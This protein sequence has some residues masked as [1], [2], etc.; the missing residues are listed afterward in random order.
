MLPVRHDPVHNHAVAAIRNSRH[1]ATVVA[2]GICIAVLGAIYGGMAFS[3]SALP[4][5][6]DVR[7]F[8]GDPL[9]VRIAVP[10][11]LERESGN[12][13]AAI[14]RN[15][16]DGL[17]RAKDLQLTMVELRAARFILVRSTVAIN[18]PVVSFVLRIGCSGEAAVDR[19][20]TV[21]LD[22]PPFTVA[23]PVQVTDA[24][25]TTAT[26]S[27]ATASG[28]WT[29]VEGDTLLSIAKGIHPRNRVRQ[30]QYL[31]AMRELNPDLGDI[32]DDAGLKAGTLLRSPDLKTLS[33]ITPGVRV[34]APAAAIITRKESGS[35]NA[36]SDTAPIAPVKN[37]S[38][39][40]KSARSK[41]VAPIR[42]RPS[43]PAVEA[44]KTST[45]KASA[46]PSAQVAA[47][48]AATPKTTEPATGFRL[49]LSSAEIDLSRS[50]NVTDEQRS[51]LREKQLMLDADD[52]V[53]ALLSLRN[54]VRQLES[55]LNEMQLKLAVTP[56]SNANKAEAKP[57]AAEPAPPIAAASAPTVTA[58]AV[59][60]KPTIALPATPATS[61]IPAAP[62][63]SADPP[64]ATASDSLSQYLPSSPTLSAIVG[65]LL[66]LLGAWWW[67]KRGRSRKEASDAN[68]D[69]PLLAVTPATSMGSVSKSDAEF[70]DWEGQRSA[71]PPAAN[72]PD[73]GPP[74]PANER[75]ADIRSAPAR[76]ADV[77]EPPPEYQ[78][79]VR[80]DS[81]VI[82]DDTPARYE[83]DSSPATTVDFPLGL[84]DKPPEDRVRRLQ[85]MHERYPELKTNTV[86]IDDADSVINAARLYY[87]EGD[88]RGGG[89]DK[90]CELLTFAVEERPQEIR[91]WLAQ[92]EIFRLEGMTAEFGALAAKFQMLFSHTPAWPKVR[93]IGHEIDPGNPLYA[94]S[95]RPSLG[96]ETRFD[97]IAENW[98]NAPMDFTSDALTSDLR[99]ALLDDHNVTRTDFEQTAEKLTATGTG[100]S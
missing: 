19:E 87:D 53:A 24:G 33:G 31:H 36:K 62:K 60:E 78:A 64:Q 5:E 12:C 61:P 16:N 82:F 44:P 63:A 32:A 34:K 26:Q 48:A 86:S 39:P 4:K 74:M 89:R 18:E 3:Q 58:A 9:N 88:N 46:K 94:E 51:A 42:S 90:A 55:R 68:A 67:S 7:S 80:I 52:Q 40:E 95:G 69:N 14:D 6:V 13:Q 22:P 98:L 50:R 81:P 57:A 45:E 21:L 99:L 66:L 96:G 93:H 17:L 41:T 8:L 43:T 37:P 65:G 49:R 77:V 27:G 91:F 97:P 47:P 30:K 10:A 84:D 1:P 20:I 35:P 54:T 2:S 79:T 38:P 71:S 92:F 72:G 100:A 23:P 76:A 56:A 73:T 83:L 28:N 15:G 59:D 75:P 85:Y 70:A 25:K 11:S 29:V